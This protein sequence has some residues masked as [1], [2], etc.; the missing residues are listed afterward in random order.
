MA[1]D[2]LEGRWKQ[3]KGRV[4]EKWGL[5]TDDDVERIAGKRDQL[6]GMVQAH[7]GEVKEEA[8]RQVAE[9]IDKYLDSR[10]SERHHGAS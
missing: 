5:F 10:D 3:L 7:Y 6:V 2:V 8:E 4:R 9:F 1:G